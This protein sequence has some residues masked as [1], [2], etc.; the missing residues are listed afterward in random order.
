MGIV[1]IIIL[2]LKII[3]TQLSWSFSTLRVDSTLFPTLP[4]CRG[5]HLP[6]FP[7]PFKVHS[8]LPA[9]TLKSDCYFL[10]GKEGKMEK[11]KEVEGKEKK[12]SFGNESCLVA[13]CACP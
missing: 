5:K 13:A 10:M 4:P 3:I 12:R 8:P 2:Q 11:E 7:F 1:I 9:S 6:F